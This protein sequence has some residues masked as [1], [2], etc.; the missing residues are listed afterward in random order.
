MP[1]VQALDFARHL[2]EKGLCPAYALVGEDT[3]LVSAC[4]SAIRSALETEDLPGSITTDHEDL[5]DAPTVFDELYTRPFMGM[6]GKRLVIVRDGQKFL[7]DYGDRVQEYLENPPAEGVLLLCCKKLDR[8]RKGAKA[9]AEFATIVDCSKL[10]WKKAR[11]WLNE[12]ASRAGK[13]L[14]P[15]AAD[16]LLEAIGADLAALSRELE[17]L[18]LYADSENTLTEEHVAELVPQSRSRS[19][20]DLSHAIARGDVST[21]IRLADHLLL[22]G[23]TPTGMI[24]FL[25]SQMR[26]LWQV[27]RLRATG[28][29][30][31]QIANKVGLPHFAVRRAAK[32]VEKRSGEWLSQ[33]INQLAEADVE[34]K[35]KSLQAA[36]RETWFEGFLVAL[37]R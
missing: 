19:I 15:R 6:E 27:K 32:A 5:P 26:T 36:E 28:A 23:E 11:R 12:R 8:R 2:K 25:G 33:C 10:R 34:L 37:A 22:R 13:A 14:T 30:Q 4:L 1:E 17:K 9:I 24:G 35:T 21:A 3:S 18:C 7:D 31:K 16:S 29:S 20:F